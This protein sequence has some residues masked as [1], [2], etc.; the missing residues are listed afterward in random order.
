MILWGLG[1]WM[2]PYAFDFFE[3][4]RTAELD[5]WIVFLTERFIFVIFG[6]FSVVG[7]YRLWRS[8]IHQSKLVP[9]GFAV[10]S[11]AIISFIFKSFFAIPRPFITN[12]SLIPLIP[13]LSASFPS[14]HT[15]VTF[16]LLVPFYRVFKPLG[17]TWG[18]FA[19]LIG[20]SRVYENVH[21]PSDIAGGIFLGGL[22]G[23]FFT[24]EEVKNAIG[25]WWE[26]ER[27]FRRQT[28]HFL[29]GFLLVFA[30]WKD[31][32]RLRHIA[33]FLIIGLALALLSS[34]KKLPFVGQF[35]ALFDRPRDL[36]FPGRGA[37]YFL[38]GVFLSIL[39]FPVKIAYASILI[40]SVGDSL[41]HM[42]GDNPRWRNFTIPWNR[43]KNIWGVLLGIA[44]GTFAA[45]FFVPF[46]PALLA[47]S[48]AILL[49]TLTFKIGKFYLNDNLYVPLVAGGILSLLI[50]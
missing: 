19:L 23:A 50:A 37:F 6:G 20:I 9:A 26:N 27:E 43:C 32:L 31:L 46:W 12:E 15:A 34:K 44:G 28:F 1:K 49:E 2:D 47:A 42:F 39:L 22:T 30:H 4:I 24:H 7:F 11:A 8:P 45:Q 5:R 13:E 10:V 41:N 35:L 40:L 18:L 38:L 48:T 25:H 17:W 29:L 3:L 16:A 21:Y 33:I 14:A 36:L